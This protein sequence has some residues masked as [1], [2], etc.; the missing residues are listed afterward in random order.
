MR[1][2]KNYAVQVTPISLFLPAVQH[3]LE[4]ITAHLKTFQVDFS[5]SRFKRFN[6]ALQSVTLFKRFFQLLDRQVSRIIGLTADLLKIGLPRLVSS[7][8]TIPD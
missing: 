3:E 2:I 6:P 7:I 1:K 8:C 4:K 5:W